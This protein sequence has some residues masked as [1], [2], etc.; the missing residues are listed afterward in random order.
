MQI[1]FPV[2]KKMSDTLTNQEKVSMF[3]RDHVF[4]MKLTEKLREGVSMCKCRVICLWSRLSR[5]IC[6][7]LD[8]GAKF[9]RS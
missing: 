3:L 4:R 1:L 2:L 8:I 9:R 7:P 6:I 5:F